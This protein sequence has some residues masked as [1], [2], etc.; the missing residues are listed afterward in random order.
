M[1]SGHSSLLSS[2]SLGDRS[3][4]ERVIEVLGLPR[5]ESGVSSK[6]LARSLNVEP[7]KLAACINELLQEARLKIEKN[8]ADIWYIL[9]NE[10]DGK[11]RA[12]LDSQ[13]LLVLQTI[14]ES[15]N[16]GIWTKDIRMRTN[17]QQ[18]AMN[19]IFRILEQR[20]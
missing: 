5:H 1:E 9:V 12:G 20:Q 17:I 19:K 4:K 16:Q 7:T 15:G 3:L 14:E 11:K 2:S 10:E 6:F 13:Q 8:N 18:Q